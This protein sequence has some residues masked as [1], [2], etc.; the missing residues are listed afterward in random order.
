[1]NIHAKE[2]HT[3]AYL[4]QR[5]HEELFGDQGSSSLHYEDTWIRFRIMRV[6]E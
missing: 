1:M 4:T 3:Y 2:T 5:N 6:R